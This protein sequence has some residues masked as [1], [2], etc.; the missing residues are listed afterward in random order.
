VRETVNR[1]LHWENTV[2]PSGAYR[3][4]LRGML[5]TLISS[6]FLCLLEMASDVRERAT[7]EA[8]DLKPPFVEGSLF[9]PNAW[10]PVKG[11]TIIS[12]QHILGT[13][14]SDVRVSF[15]YGDSISFIST[16]RVNHDD[17][18]ARIVDIDAGGT[19]DF[20]QSGSLRASLYESLS[21]E[22]D[23]DIAHCKMLA[24]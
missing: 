21:T 16:F 10:D 23:V 1:F 20:C 4:D 7:Q 5:P 6:E 8:P 17:K 24:R 13:K 15:D 19:C 11:S 14:E 22:V 9:M 18:S 12:S 3:K 2:K